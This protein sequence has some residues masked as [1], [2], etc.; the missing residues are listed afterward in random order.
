MKAL[1]SLFKTDNDVS[2]FFYDSSFH[3]QR[4]LLPNTEKPEQP[5]PGKQKSSLHPRRP[6]GS[7]EELTG[8]EVLNNPNLNKGTVFSDDKA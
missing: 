6:S 8:I 7:T 2:T 4:S 5:Y 1:N 3:N